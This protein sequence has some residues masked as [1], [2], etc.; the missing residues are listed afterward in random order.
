MIFKYSWEENRLLLSSNNYYLNTDSFSAPTAGYRNRTPGNENMRN[1]VDGTKNIKEIMT[2]WKPD[3]FLWN[4]YLIKGTQYQGFGKAPRGNL[5][6]WVGIDL[7]PF[8]SYL[9]FLLG[10]I[11]NENHFLGFQNYMPPSSPKVR[12]GREERSRKTGKQA[13]RCMTQHIS[14]HVFYTEEIDKSMWYV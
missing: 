12:E 3:H 13:Q 14:V 1:K 9:K 7:R 8:S 5:V 6:G 2:L 4:N 11:L 10:L